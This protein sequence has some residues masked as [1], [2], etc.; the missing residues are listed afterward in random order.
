MT[1]STPNSAP[2]TVSNQKR[3][4]ILSQISL[5]EIQNAYQRITP[6]IHQTPIVTSEQLNRFLGHNIWF[7]AEC[8]QKVGAFKARGACNTIAKLAEQGKL[9]E[10]VVANSS[11]NHAQ[12]VAWAARQFGIKVTIYM[13]ANV[14][15]IKAQ[16]TRAYGANVVL[17]ETRAI[18]DEQVAKAA[19][20][21]NTLWI[22]PYNHPDVI[23][24]QGTATFEAIGQLQDM[25]Q[26]NLNC[27]VA[28]CGGGGLLSGTLV[29]ATGLLGDIDVIGAEPL[30]ANDA[31]ESLRTGSIQKLKTPPVT[32]ADGAMTPSLG[33][34]TFEIVKNVAGF[35]EVNEQ[36]IAYWTQWLQH[37]L[38]LH[39]EPTSAMSMAAV[40]KWLADKKDKQDVLVILTGGNIDNANMNK[41][42][43][44]DYL[45]ELP[46]LT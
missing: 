11:G 12:A 6:F 35:Y 32:L 1:N 18:A 33:D 42:W 28:P 3:N 17:C 27:V 44:Q 21:P 5:T 25:H 2:S 38:K 8:L 22:P 19:E 23:C 45:T 43:A 10:H 39:V 13:P 4:Q 46:A 20:R 40:C 41:I 14:S 34:I 30:N 36:N 16:A 26:V 9:P 31:A 24:G 15:K 29:A 7:K 37:L